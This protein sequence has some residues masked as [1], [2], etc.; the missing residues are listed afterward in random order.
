MKR[1]STWFAL[2]LIAS[3]LFLSAANNGTAESPSQPNQRSQTKTPAQEHDAV[4]S[5]A[6]PVSNQPAAVPTASAGATYIY[7][8]YKQSSPWGDLPTWLEALATILLVIYAAWQT[9]FV[10]RSTKAAEDAAKAATLA[11]NA[12]RPYLLPVQAEDNLPALLQIAT[13][14]IKN[15]GKGPAIISEIVA[16]FGLDD[17]AFPIPADFSRCVPVTRITRKVIS[18]DDSLTFDVETKEDLREAIHMTVP[19]F[20]VI[21]L[22]LTLRGIIRYQDVFK[23]PHTTTFGFQ[24]IP[25]VLRVKWQGLPPTYH[26]VF[27]NNAAYNTFD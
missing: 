14:T 2:I 13:V 5:Q 3:A 8:Q 26:Q 1:S 9:S 23:Q 10:D 20:M 16:H 25:P 15:F 27:Q 12:E 18:P 6:P 24:Y 21:D 17:P 19:S 11:L 4:A 7:N 22:R